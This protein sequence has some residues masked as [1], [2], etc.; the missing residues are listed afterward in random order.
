MVS[1]HDSYQPN[2]TGSARQVLVNQQHFHPYGP[3]YGPSRAQEQLSQPTVPFSTGARPTVYLEGNSVWTPQHGYLPEQGTSFPHRNEQLTYSHYPHNGASGVEY[4]QARPG[5]FEGNPN[6]RPVSHQ[7]IQNGYGPPLNIKTYQS[8]NYS[9]VNGPP[10]EVNSQYQTSQTVISPTRDQ[11]VHRTNSIRDPQVEK[12]KTEHPPPIRNFRIPE[13]RE[14]TGHEPSNPPEPTNPSEPN[15]VCEVISPDLKQPANIIKLTPIKQVAG[16]K[17]AMAGQ[18]YH[19]AELATLPT[20]LPNREFVRAAL[21][22]AKQNR[23]EA[24]YSPRKRRPKPE[25]DVTSG[26]SLSDA[27]VKLLALKGIPDHREDLEV[28]PSDAAS[29]RQNAPPSIASTGEGPSNSYI[30]SSESKAN[31]VFSR[32]VRLFPLELCSAITDVRQKKELMTPESENSSGH[33]EDPADG[34][35][36]KR[37][38]HRKTATPRKSSRTRG[39]PGSKKKRKS[40]TALSPQKRSRPKVDSRAYNSNDDAHGSDDP[41]MANQTRANGKKRRDFTT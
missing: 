30:T 37:K 5:S 41:A 12:N 39:N 36:G 33:A 40:E 34:D 32:E 28:N 19:E 18:W 2:Y 14:Q 8:G 1:G 38:P 13:V 16:K 35:Y 20:S 25:A 11:S 29:G 7:P 15:N 22:E 17:V 24:K 3:S 6:P 10:N 9:S 27:A 21:K 26:F 4:S 23:T 31:Y